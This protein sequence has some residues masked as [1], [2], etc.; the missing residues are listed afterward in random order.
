MLNSPN[1]IYQ[2]SSVQTATPGQL[3]IMLYEGAIRYT[4]AGI[5]GIQKRDNEMTNTNLKKAQSIV[6]EL[7]AS[8]NHEY[9]IS[10]DLARIYEYLLHLLIQS[11]MKKD[12]APANEVLEHLMELRDAWKQIVKGAF[13]EAKA[14]SI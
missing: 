11:N 3:V 4:K 13:N 2:K 7:I 10:K 9:E 12:L 1:Q 14:G 6:H 8:L 5:V